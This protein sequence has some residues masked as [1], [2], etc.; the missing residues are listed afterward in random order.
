MKTNITVKSVSFWFCIFIASILLSTPIYRIGTISS[1]L[2]I[3]FIFSAFLYESLVLM[4]KIK[5]RYITIMYLIFW[6]YS[7]FI[8]L[9]NGILGLSNFL[10]LSS[11]FLLFLIISLTSFDE[12]VI[13]CIKKTIIFT[14][15]MYGIVVLFAIVTKMN[16][17]Y[18]G[19]IYFFGTKFDPNSIGIVFIWGALLSISFLLQTKS[20]F[21]FFILF[22]NILVIVLTASRGSFLSLSISS[23]ILI[24][25]KLDRTKINMLK[26]KNLLFLIFLLISSIIIYLS[27]NNYFPKELERVLNIF[28]G[29]GG[30]GRLD[31]WTNAIA[32]WK[33][34][35]LF[36][37]GYNSYLLY[38]KQAIHNTYIQI[39]CDWGLIGFCFICAYQI[40][41]GIKVFSSDIDFFSIFIGTVVALVFLDGFG[42]KAFWIVLILISLNPKKVP[43]ERTYYAK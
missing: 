16:Q 6:I 35:P 5:I 1:F 41:F 12:H 21:Y 8:S 29:S 11:F 37:Q 30:N 20:L 2:I 43:N 33:K 40:F 10:K 24:I 7:T 17:Y 36:G 28:D 19:D 9:S 25:Y 39:L 32:F 15:F 38:Y 26:V 31:I 13:C 34:S 18:H 14:S 3:L 27:I 23:L 22:F 4:K 42:E